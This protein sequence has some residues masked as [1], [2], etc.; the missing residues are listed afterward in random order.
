MD[1]MYIGIIILKYIGI[2]WNILECIGMYWTCCELW[3]INT[4][5]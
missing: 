1:E 2:Y 4:N 3:D 5:I